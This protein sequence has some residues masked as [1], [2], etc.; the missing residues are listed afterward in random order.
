MTRRE[1]AARQALNFFSEESA[2][3]TGGHQAGRKWVDY[4][5]KGEITAVD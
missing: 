1:G 4:G 3:I 2:T 5:L